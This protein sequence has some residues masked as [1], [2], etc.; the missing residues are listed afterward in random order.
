MLKYLRII[1]LNYNIL[2]LIKPLLNLYND[3]IDAEI[4]K[5]VLL[6]FEKKGSFDREMRFD[7]NKFRGITSSIILH[8]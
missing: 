2:Q 8:L 1:I 5:R 3:D 4:Y 7:Q 6:V